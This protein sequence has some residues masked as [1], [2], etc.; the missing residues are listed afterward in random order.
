MA[1]TLIFLLLA[2]LYLVAAAEAAGE[3]QPEAPTIT[4]EPV[5]VFD[6]ANL[7]GEPMAITAFG[8]RVHVLD[9]MDHVVWSID[10]PTGEVASLDIVDGQQ[11]YDL[12]DACGGVLHVVDPLR[13]GLLKQRPG[14]MAW[15]SVALGHR[16]F[17]G[18]GDD[19]AV[20]INANRHG[21]AH[22]A[23][24]VGCDGDTL[25]LGTLLRHDHPYASVTANLNYTRVAMS[26]DLVAIGHIALAM[27][28]IL[29]R[30]GTPLATVSLNG[31]EVI[32]SRRMFLQN[33]GV[34]VDRPLSV[35]RDTLVADLVRVARP[36]R[37]TVPVY[38]GGLAVR[39]R[40]VYA[41][42]NNVVHVLEPDGR[43]RARLR[44]GGRHRD[45]RV[46]LHTFCLDEEGRLYGLDRVHY[47]KIY[48][49]GPVDTM[50]ADPPDTEDEGKT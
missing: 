31:P 4:I 25:G 38:I 40:L 26:T 34:P 42:V 20:L 13:R 2:A 28:Q 36:E 19:H 41:L 16:V 5:A 23:L 14:Q 1:R 27:V 50:L 3:G 7:L 10:L 24:L 17:F 33:H 21:R 6:A 37:F 22:I 9:G 45:E 35:E 44:V 11:P 46:L 32:D 43:L 15:E 12:F 30:N 39:G 8:G 18:D 48:D 49:F 29:A 47:R